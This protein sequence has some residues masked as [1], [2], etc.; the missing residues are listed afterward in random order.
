MRPWHGGVMT[1]VALLMAQ[2]LWFTVEGAPGDQLPDLFM[3]LCF[4]GIITLTP[5]IAYEGSSDSSEGE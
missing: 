3:I 5:C 4:I 1:G 2:Y